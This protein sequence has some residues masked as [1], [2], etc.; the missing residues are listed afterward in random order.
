[1]ETPD[2]VRDFARMVVR[3]FYEDFFIVLM[4]AV[5]RERNYAREEKLAKATSL[6]E[7]EVRTMLGRMVEERLLRRE[8]QQFRRHTRQDLGKNPRTVQE[9]FYYVDFLSLMDMFR[10]RLEHVRAKLDQDVQTEQD[11]AIMYV[12]PACEKTFGALDVVELI[13]DGDSFLC[14]RELRKNMPCGAALE[15]AR[16]R[17]QHARAKELRNRLEDEIRPLLELLHACRDVKIPRHPLE[18]ASDKR[19]AELVPEDT[20]DEGMV[21]RTGVR[22]SD[23]SQAAGQADNLKRFE[24]Y[25]APTSRDVK[26]EVSFAAS[27][28]QVNS[29]A[30]NEHAA[31]PAK[32]SWFGNS[33]ELNEHPST[34]ASGSPVVLPGHVDDL[35]ATVG[36][37][38]SDGQAYMEAYLRSAQINRDNV[39]QD[40]DEDQGG[41]GTGPGPRGRRRTESLPS[42]TVDLTTITVRVQGVEMPITQVTELHQANMTTE[43]FLDFHEKL[44]SQ[45]GDEPDDEFEEDNFESM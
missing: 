38:P 5:L 36:E 22:S 43:E 30:G 41:R 9:Y 14:D 16:Q 35:S 10:Y 12:C 4:D 7:K 15:D 33:G 40:D 3:Y 25:D 42:Q 34:T 13:P 18:E 44:K 37:S 20:I 8:K 24:Y 23:P 26:V 27:E 31:I 28:G 2:A 19:W 17:V 32:P 45:I 6:P 21:V 39:E 29:G 11:H 1:M